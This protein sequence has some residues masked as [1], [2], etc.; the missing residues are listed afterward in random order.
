M[1]DTLPPRPTAD[2]REAG[3]RAALALAALGGFAVGMKA[4]QGS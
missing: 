2:D 3:A 4:G 1:P